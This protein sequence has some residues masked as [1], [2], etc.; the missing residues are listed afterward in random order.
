MCFL[1]GKQIRRRRWQ[2]R[3]LSLG[4]AQQITKSRFDGEAINTKAFILAVLGVLI[5][6]SGVRVAEAQVI[7]S[8]G[9]RRLRF[10]RNN[11][12]RRLFKLLLPTWK[13]PF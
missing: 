2:A 10:G 1:S 8:L 9:R 12:K 6:S 3:T 5:F 11:R 4:M 13:S 7:C